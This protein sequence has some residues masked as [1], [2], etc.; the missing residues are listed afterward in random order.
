M[1][2]HKLKEDFAQNKSIGYDS[3][4]AISNTLYSVL[5]PFDDSIDYVFFIAKESYSE[6]GRAH[7]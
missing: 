3:R 7:V 5:K 6:I 1:I 2:Y 4:K